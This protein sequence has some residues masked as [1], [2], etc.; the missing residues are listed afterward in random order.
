MF[1][2]AQ[3]LR[4]R[5]GKSAVWSLDGLTQVYVEVGKVNRGFAQRL[6]VAAKKDANVNA[7]VNLDCFAQMVPLAAEDTLNEI[8][9]YFE[10]Y[11]K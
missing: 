5:E 9:P 11:L 3:L 6:R 4:A 1:L 8:R 10:A 2:M 7:L